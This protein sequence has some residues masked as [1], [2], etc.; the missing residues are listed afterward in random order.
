[1]QDAGMQMSL[2][3]WIGRRMF[4]SVVMSRLRREVVACPPVSD[5][6]ADGQPVSPASI[7]CEDGTK[8]QVRSVA[9]SS[10]FLE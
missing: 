6:V 5:S 2:E 7:A 10:S 8:A 3:I 4:T 9:A 1:M